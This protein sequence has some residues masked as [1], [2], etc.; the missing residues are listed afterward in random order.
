MNVNRNLVSR[1]SFLAAQTGR[2]IGPG[3]ELAK[4]AILTKFFTKAHTSE[5]LMKKIKH[6]KLKLRDSPGLVFLFRSL[7]FWNSMAKVDS[8]P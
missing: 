1:T 6:L 7:Q 4:T 8:D 2:E 3:N 5:K